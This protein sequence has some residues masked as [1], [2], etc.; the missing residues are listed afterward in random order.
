MYFHINTILF[1]ALTITCGK[2]IY[3]KMYLPVKIGKKLFEY[4]VTGESSNAMATN[5]HMSFRF[6]SRNHMCNM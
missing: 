3:Q 6:P 5:M 2:D 4:Y 1:A